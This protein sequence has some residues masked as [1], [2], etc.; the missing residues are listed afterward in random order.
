MSNKII[1]IALEEAQHLISEEY[2]SIA[3][4]DLRQRY[5]EVLKKIKKAINQIKN[6]KNYEN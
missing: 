1:L 4:E 3:D 5:D 6:R 2:Q